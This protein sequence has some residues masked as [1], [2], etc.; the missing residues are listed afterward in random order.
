M[1]RRAVCRRSPVELE[2]EVGALAP[3][4]FF[5]GTRGQGEVEERPVAEGKLRRQAPGPAPRQALDHLGKI[6]MI[7][8]HLP[9]TDGRELVL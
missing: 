8:V 4:C 6:Q 5:G 1:R 3:L 7:D 2:G 9:T